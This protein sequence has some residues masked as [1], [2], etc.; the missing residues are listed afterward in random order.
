[1]SETLEELKKYKEDI[2]RKIQIIESVKDREQD[3]I[4]DRKTLI[5]CLNTLRRNRT[6]LEEK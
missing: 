2:E 6:D 1:M 5:Y 4:Y 3:Q